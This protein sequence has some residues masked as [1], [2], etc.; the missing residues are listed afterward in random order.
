MRTML[1]LSR[2][3][4]LRPMVGLC[5]VLWAAR[6]AAAPADDDA[7]TNVTTV[8]TGKVVA[9]V[10]GDTM[11]VLDS[12]GAL[13]RVRLLGADAP[14][15]KQSSGARAKD[16]LSEK[17]LGQVLT[18]TLSDRDRYGCTLGDVHLQDRWINQEMI[19]EG[20]AWYYKQQTQNRD[21]ADAE[22][23]ARD[24]KLG[25]WQDK[26][27]TAPWDF[28]EGGRSSDRETGAGS[29]RSTGSEW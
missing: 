18:I 1:P 16:V 21:L 9:V 10:D 23:R 27:P 5:L 26:N 7:E 15:L 20:W 14:E 17:V 19:R 29:P 11:K 4:R 6:S 25:L 22:K 12:G 8:V 2:L 13:R 3:A 24:G 28:R